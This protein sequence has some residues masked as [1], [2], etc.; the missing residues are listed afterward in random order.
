M[1]Y[2]PENPLSGF[3]L[4]FYSQKIWAKSVTNPAKNFTEVLWLRK[5]ARQVELKYVGRPFA[6]H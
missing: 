1:Q 5:S 3:I 4:G 2:E 6:G